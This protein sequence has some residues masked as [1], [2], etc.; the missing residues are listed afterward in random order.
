MRSSSSPEL[1]SSLSPIMATG[2]PL[3]YSFKEMKSCAEIETEDPRSGKKKALVSPATTGHDASAGHLDP[4]DNATS[5]SAL[6]LKSGNS[7][8]LPSGL[9]IQPGTGT[10]KRVVHIATTAV[11]LN[12]NQLDTIVGLPEVL[13][14]AMNDPFTR[15]MSLDLSFNQL[16][17]VETPLLRFI[18]LKVLY[19]HGNLI[20]SLQSVDRL[21][22][23]PKLISLTLQGNPIQSQKAYR[24]FILGA[25]PQIK[26]L[27]HTSIAQQ[28]IKDAAVWLKK[29]LEDMRLKREERL[30]KMQEADV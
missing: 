7:T 28:E 12:N 26:T 8:A 13:E 3:D 16:K 11:K 1:L 20:T 14:M 17:S 19:M 10:P 9:R 21:K 18:N 27:D 30:L 2:P 6:A 29:W 4:T 23:L 24:Q 15:L 22:K 25:V 5:S